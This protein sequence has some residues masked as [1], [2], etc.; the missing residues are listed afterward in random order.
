MST[1]LDLSK[2][3]VKFDLSNQD[4][5][6]RALF[7]VRTSELPAPERNKLRD[8][9]FLLS[10][11]GDQNLRVRLEGDLHDVPISDDY[12]TAIS[13][14]DE[15]D[16][17]SDASNFFGGR[18]EPS[19]AV[20]KLVRV[21][22]SATVV[23]ESD[24]NASGA[25]D[26][27]V[28]DASLSN[29]AN[30]KEQINSKNDTQNHNA[31]QLTSAGDQDSKLSAEVDNVA[32][33]S[34]TRSSS[35]LADLPGT[36]D[37][38]EKSFVADSAHTSATKT[39]SKSDSF[40]SEQ[41][42][43]QVQQNKEAAEQAVYLKRIQ[44]IKSYI[45]E[46]IGNPVNLVDLDNTTGRAY[47]TALLT[48]MQSA[49]ST[50]GLVTEVDMQSL[51]RAFVDVKK[52]LHNN[53]QKVNAN[54]IASNQVPNSI[55]QEVHDKNIVPKIN[56]DSNTDANIS[57]KSVNGSVSASDLDLKLS[58]ANQSHDNSDNKS[59][60]ENFANDKSKGNIDFT[61]HH[62][63]DKS[64]DILDVPINQ[65]PTKSSGQSK[66]IQKP[67]PTK[68]IPVRSA[69]KPESGKNVR[70]ESSVKKSTAPL[71]KDSTPAKNAANS[72]S[73]DVT[74]VKAV[75]K[76]QPSVAHDASKTIDKKLAALDA[77]A[78]ARNKYDGD[79][80]YA[81]EVDD[82]LQH[83][84]LEWSLFKSSGLF[85][86]GPNGRNHPL[87]KKLA[88]EMVNDILLG[89]FDGSRPEIIQ[90]IT[91]YMNGWRYEQGIVYQ[92]G[93]SFELYLRRVIRFILDQNK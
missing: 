36:K 65:L 76:E 72:T 58:K 63:T 27:S 7:A 3:E 62:V 71:L 22:E 85:G 78:A 86:T 75:T 84:L 82:G 51:E 42:V 19:F 28:Q 45:S 43:S 5:I 61:P 59:G 30:L 70:P 25:S 12:I 77:A 6:L 20:R 55:K 73:S 1:G 44:E 15:Q 31:K 29:P 37:G 49:N 4:G 17:L 67:L 80:L 26:L 89:R 57:S 56:N 14:L 48:V 64:D 11:T 40:R 90:S 35:D 53:Q 13:K 39:D 2:K 93:E 10:R 32:S 88:P 18:R 46:R 54:I 60:D 91:D 68:P 74:P 21:K 52:L 8:Q 81:P 79:P 92:P 23:K 16:K 69:Q 24:I 9:L 66:N 41:V 87:F 38:A 47:M 33:I 50:T 34:N 83:L